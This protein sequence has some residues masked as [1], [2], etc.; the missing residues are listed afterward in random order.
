MFVAHT[1]ARCNITQNF[2]FY[3]FCFSPSN[4]KDSRI[5]NEQRI[6]DGTEE[7]AALYANISHTSLSSFLY[8]MYVFCLTHSY[9]SALIFPKKKHTI[10]KQWHILWI[11]KKHSGIKNEHGFL[12]RRILCCFFLLFPVQSGPGYLYVTEENVHCLIFRVCTHFR[13][14]SSSFLDTKFRFNEFTFSNRTHKKTVS[15]KSYF[16]QL[17]FLLFSR[18]ILPTSLTCISIDIQNF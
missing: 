6:H 8:L 7:H 16:G 1:N 9:A 18:S 10:Q 17:F 11:H 3:C 12:K 4:P 15:A 14:R 5:K 2:I 13:G